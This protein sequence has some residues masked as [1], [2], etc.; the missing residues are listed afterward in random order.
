MYCNWATNSVQVHV[1]ADSP[2]VWRYLLDPALSYPFLEAGRQIV[3]ATIGS[4]NVASLRAARHLGFTELARVRDGFEAG[5]DVVFLELR[6]ENCRR[7]K[8][9]RKAA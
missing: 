7:L 9:N 5:S 2:M 4:R 6:R 3:I 1:A 8:Q